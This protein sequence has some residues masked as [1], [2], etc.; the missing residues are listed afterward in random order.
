MGG[1]FWTDTTAASYDPI[2]MSLMGGISSDFAAVHNTDIKE[3]LIL[4]DKEYPRSYRYQFMGTPLQPFSDNNAETRG[5]NF[6]LLRA[7]AFAY[8]Q[9]GERE[10]M[11][12]DNRGGRVN[13]GKGLPTYLYGPFYEAHQQIAKHPLGQGSAHLNEIAYR[14]PVTAA[15]RQEEKWL[16]LTDRPEDPLVLSQLINLLTSHETVFDGEEIRFER[17]FDNETLEHYDD[18][19]ARVLQNE[20]IRRVPALEP[21]DDIEFSE[22]AAPDMPAAPDDAPDPV[23]TSTV[24]PGTA[25]PGTISAPAAPSPAQPGAPPVI[26]YGTPEVESGATG[27]SVTGTE[28][29]NE[30]DPYDVAASTLT[31]ATYEVDNDP[32]TEIGA[33]ST[34][35][36]ALLD[37]LTDLVAGAEIASVDM[38]GDLTAP[39]IATA[40]M[41]VWTD[42]DLAKWLGMVSSGAQPLPDMTGLPED[43]E[44]KVD[45][46]VAAYTALANDRFAEER[47]RLEAQAF[48]SRAIMTTYYDNA[49][50][51]LS[52]QQQMQIADYDAKLRLEQLNMDRQAAVQIEQQR[53]AYRQAMGDLVTRL[54]EMHLR[55]QMTDAENELRVDLSN[56]EHAI[57]VLKVNAELEQRAAQANAE[58]NIQGK[59]A[60]ADHDTRMLLTQIDWLG[61]SALAT[62]ENTLRAAMANQETGLRASTQSKEN[63]LR[64]AVTN[65]E[66]LLRAAIATAENLT[67]AE[68]TNVETGTRLAI[69]G[70]ENITRASTTA[71]DLSVRSAMAG[72]ENITRAQ[73]A[74]AQ[75]LL[76]ASMALAE[77]ATRVSLA[78]ADA[79][80]RAKLSGEEQSVRVGLA[81]AENQM[82][83]LDLRAK[84]DLT[85]IENAVRILL[86]NT[87]LEWKTENTNR[88]NDLRT[89]ISERDNIMGELRLRAEVANHFYLHTLGW[90]N[91]KT[92]NA[93]ALAQIITTGMQQHTQ[94]Q[95][96]EREF[97][98]NAERARWDTIARRADLYS[99]DAELRWKSMIQNQM[100]IKEACSALGIVPT[101]V[102]HHPS[103]F[104][105]VTEG[106]GG[107]MTA[108]SLGL[109]AVNLF[110]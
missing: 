48:S 60:Y 57:D 46:A 49:L 38:P 91:A 69:A 1:N 47:A 65:A 34:K 84:Y 110:S 102:E 44:A 95:L 105:R 51:I 96:G 23:Q 79:E 32:T 35:I 85:E 86:A 108:A 52:G 45:A 98:L 25:T 39:T 97:E 8:A 43:S 12:V 70:A 67:R 21:V 30:G 101:G 37:G 76:Q 53:F 88:D 11:A 80:T 17:L 109:Q 31:E 64:V 104:S 10:D 6:G 27:E 16:Q 41:P 56:Y 90:L 99:G 50:A 26:N 81:D 71:G 106:A 3:R 14:D 66:N 24:T 33:H 77:H 42:S 62:A 63:S 61:K 7:S 36:E 89:Q 19:I 28:I 72:A 94:R 82:R 87:D 103:G 75:N 18:L 9:G 83:L 2:V 22:I 100:V 54:T 59:L 20:D 55:Y 4:N 5:Y 40:N 15:K 78:N 74:H 92:S 73:I 93:G 13:L 107:V 29:P 68:L 58:I